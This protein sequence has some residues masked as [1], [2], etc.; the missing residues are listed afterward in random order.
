MKLS[1]LH[2]CKDK[3]VQLSLGNCTLCQI[4]VLSTN[5]DEDIHRYLFKNL[6]F[7]EALDEC[8]EIARHNVSQT[9]KDRLN[10]VKT[11]HLY[12]IIYGAMEK[13]IAFY[14]DK[15]HEVGG[16]PQDNTQIAINEYLKTIKFDN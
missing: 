12:D 10:Q 6:P 9:I 13:E 3:H 5:D 8:L 2:K 1:E 4:A 15:A 11:A 16:H 7:N 14:R